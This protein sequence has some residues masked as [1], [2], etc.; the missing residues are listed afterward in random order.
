ML[1]GNVHVSFSSE[2]F[3]IHGLNAE[4][5]VGVI[6][7]LCLCSGKKQMEFEIIKGIW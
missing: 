1:S 4:N 3:Y 2:A 5:T 7:I 6:L